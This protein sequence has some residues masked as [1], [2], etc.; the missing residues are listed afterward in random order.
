ML[1]TILS[2]WF[3]HFICLY[4]HGAVHR[5]RI[6]VCWESSGWFL[7]MYV[8]LNKLR[9]ELMSAL[10]GSWSLL[11]LKVQEARSLGAWSQ[12]VVSWP[13]GRRQCGVDGLQSDMFFSSISSLRLSVCHW[14]CFVKFETMSQTLVD[15]CRLLTSSR[16]LWLLSYEMTAV[17][18]SSFH[19]IIS[20]LTLHQ[21]RL[22][23]GLINEFG[24]GCWSVNFRAA[25]VGLHC[26]TAA[27]RRTTLP[28]HMDKSKAWQTC[29]T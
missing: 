25:D 7:Q 14:K 5:L 15:K 1:V 22:L 24:W 21:K 2:K 28:Q 3:V 17:G 6:S 16:H 12:N 10:K 19:F 11:R 23:W 4:S 20:G 13:R 26:N 27:T 8:C 29:C 18:S 9:T